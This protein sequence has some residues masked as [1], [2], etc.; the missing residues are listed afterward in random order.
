VLD[1]FNCEVTGLETYREQVFDL[2]KQLVYLDGFDRDDV[3]APDEEEDDDG[4]GEDGEGEDGKSVPP[5]SV[6]AT[7]RCYIHTIFI[8]CYG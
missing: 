8:L 3:E 4:E 1:L 6:C 5:A 2:L 7:V